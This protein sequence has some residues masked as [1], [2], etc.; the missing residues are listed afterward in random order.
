MKELL[1]DD[2]ISIDKNKEISLEVSFDA[3]IVTKKGMKL[4]SIFNKEEIKNSDPL[5]EKIEK[6]YF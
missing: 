3:I 6:F 1:F 4:I 2:F 5:K